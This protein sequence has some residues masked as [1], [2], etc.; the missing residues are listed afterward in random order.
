LAYDVSWFAERVEPSSAMRSRSLR[1]IPFH[2]T[3]QSIP[4]CTLD[5]SLVVGTLAFLSPGSP[6][7]LYHT[8]ARRHPCRT[9]SCSRSC[10]VRNT[11]GVF[12][13]FF[14]LQI[15]AVEPHRGPNRS[16]TQHSILFIIFISLSVPVYY[17]ATILE[18]LLGAY[19]RQATNK[20]Q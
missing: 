11:V 7:H 18:A 2:C 14:W 8:W 17:A 3:L 10:F 16:G 19:E 6:E 12:Y 20:V 1:N 13:F 9:A 5:R 15:C 4:P